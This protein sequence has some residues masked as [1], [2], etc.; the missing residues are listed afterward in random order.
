MSWW[1]RKEF[2]F[3]LPVNDIKTQITK[4][5]MTYQVNFMPT[6]ANN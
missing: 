5:K 3:I 1:D 4:N 6:F 2:V